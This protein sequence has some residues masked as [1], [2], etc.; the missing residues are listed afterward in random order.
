MRWR[1]TRCA[2]RLLNSTGY[3]GTTPSLQNLIELQRG[4]LNR[5]TNLAVSLLISPIS[6]C[7]FR[8]FVM[9]LILTNEEV[10][11]AISMRDCIEAL[12]DGF[13]EQAQGRAINQIRYDI[14]VPLKQRAERN[15][16]Y[17]FKTMVRHSPRSEW[18]HCE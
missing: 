16:R 6:H 11:A 15:A 17:E 10:A 2:S 14:N 4:R 3:T 9:T 8:I 13:R 7:Q 12:E 5:R 18:Q 1:T